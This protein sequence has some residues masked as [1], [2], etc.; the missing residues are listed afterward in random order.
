MARVISKKTASFCKKT[1]A[2]L[3]NG[4]LTF[5]NE[6]LSLE[7][8][9]SHLKFCGEAL[10]KGPSKGL[11]KRFFKRKFSLKLTKKATKNL[12]FKTTRQ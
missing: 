6:G 7:N 5:Q 4:S 1:R 10:Q 3:E 2:I 11:K 9:P 8:A 12:T